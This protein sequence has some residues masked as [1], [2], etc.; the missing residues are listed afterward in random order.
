MAS[1]GYGPDF[2]PLLQALQSYA[3]QETSQANSRFDASSQLASTALSATANIRKWRKEDEEESLLKDTLMDTP[4]GKMSAYALAKLG[5]GN[6]FEAVRSMVLTDSLLAREKAIQS[7]TDFFSLLARNA[8][9]GVPETAAS[10]DPSPEAEATLRAAAADATAQAAVPGAPQ[11][12]AGT[13]RASATG[14]AENIQAPSIVQPAGVRGGSMLRNLWFPNAAAAL[15]GEIPDGLKLPR[16]ANGDLMLPHKDA[17]VFSW[18][19]NKGPE[20]PMAEIPLGAYDYD[21]RTKT[22]SFDPNKPKDR[23]AVRAHYET[24]QKNTWAK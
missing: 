1:R 17:E 4:R 2:G 14:V 7:A 5:G 22:Y 6:V 19:P 10:V 12:P 15:M 13:A 23:E 21:P 8:Q 16:K 20:Q 9:A 11:V 18:D 24:V 3:G